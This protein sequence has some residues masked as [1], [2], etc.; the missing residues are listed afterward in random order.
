V[1]VWYQVITLLY[2]HFKFSFFILIFITKRSCEIRNKR[3]YRFI[4]TAFAALRPRTLD[5]ADLFMVAQR[6]Q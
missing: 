2:R 6:S 4:V 1:D 3:K 5:Q